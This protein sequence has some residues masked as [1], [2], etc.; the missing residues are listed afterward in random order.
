MKIA[1]IGTGTMGQPMRANLLGKVFDVVVFDVVPAALEAAIASG[2]TRAGAECL[3]L[4]PGLA[5]AVRL[6][7]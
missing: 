3:S 4:H 6:A 7:T 5:G 2:A 1:L